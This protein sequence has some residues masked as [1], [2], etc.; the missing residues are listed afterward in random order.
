VVRLRGERTQ[1]ELIE[2]YRSASLFVLAPHVLENGDRDGIP[3]VLMEAMST[4]LPVV[5]TAVSGIP[6]LIEDGRSGL[7]VP[8]RDEGALAAALARLLDPQDGPTLR[9]QLGAAG[10]ER[11]IARFDAT[12]HIG[13]MVELLQTGTAFAPEPAP[14]ESASAARKLQAGGGRP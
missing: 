7:L 10:R 5:G 3:N 6:E 1:D 9:A 12:L 4:G 14:L 11:T 2:I 13:R 8:Q